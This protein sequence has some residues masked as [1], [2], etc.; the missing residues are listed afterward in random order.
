[1]TSL[2]SLTTRSKYT[3]GRSGTGQNLLKFL[4]EMQ[5]FSKILHLGSVLAKLF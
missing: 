5:N 2:Q 1:M 4:T 3:V